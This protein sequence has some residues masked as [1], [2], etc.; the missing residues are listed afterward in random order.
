MTQKKLAQVFGYLDMLRESGVTN[1]YGAAPYLIRDMG[2]TREQA[3]SELGLWM[4]TFSRELAK[5]R[6]KIAISKAP[7]TPNV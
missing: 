2:R 4:K 3:V 5:E 7:G 1:M 6:A